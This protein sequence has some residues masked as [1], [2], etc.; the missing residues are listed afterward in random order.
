MQHHA[1]AD[2]AAL[3]DR[4]PRL[5]PRVF[6]DRGIRAD[7]SADVHDAAA[8][9]ARARSHVCIRPEVRVVGEHGALL[10]DGRRVPERT[11]RP[12]RAKRFEQA[13]ECEPRVLDHEQGF[14]RAGGV[15]WNRRIHEH[16]AGLAGQSGGQVFLF[17]GES[18]GVGRGLI[19]R[20]DASDRRRAV[21]DDPRS[22][23]LREILQRSK[24]RATAVSMAK[25]TESPSP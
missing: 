1:I 7:V 3:H 2:A 18:Q 4:R 20:R 21:A 9:D 25:A 23:G 16:R 14:A 5:Q 17:D 22:K 15:E 11:A 12:R 24:H 8:A 10:D 13:R 6:A 19:H